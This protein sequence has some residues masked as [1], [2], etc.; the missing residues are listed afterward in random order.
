MHVIIILDYQLILSSKHFLIGI[1]NVCF[2]WTVWGISDALYPM[3]ITTE[4]IMSCVRGY[5]LIIAGNFLYLIYRFI[6]CQILNKNCE[7]SQIENYS[8]LIVTVRKPSKKNKSTTYFLLSCCFPIFVWLL[9]VGF[10][11]I[12]R[13]IFSM[14]DYFLKWMYA[15]GVSNIIMC[16]MLQ[17][18]IGLSLIFTL[19][20]NA[21]NL[22]P[23]HEMYQYDEIQYLDVLLNFNIFTHSYELIQQEKLEKLEKKRE[24]VEK[25]EVLLNYKAKVSYG[26]IAKDIPVTKYPLNNY[27][28]IGS[29]S[30][31]NNIELSNESQN[32]SNTIWK[33][34][35]LKGNFRNEELKSTKT[36]HFFHNSSWHCCCGR[37]L[38]YICTL[39]YR[40]I[41]LHLF[42]GVFW[43]STW[44]IYDIITQHCFDKTIKDLPGLFT[45]ALVCHCLNHLVLFNFK[46]HTTTIPY[47]ALCQFF[48]GINTVFMWASIWYIFDNVASVIGEW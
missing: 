20:D 39:H 29:F 17:I 23:T 19:K 14:V 26:S 12:W 13:G 7:Q 44:R 32:V 5:I 48:S 8:N 30:R 6:F 22:C 46:H 42:G 35:F 27:Y 3:N 21:I 47:K 18:V 34:R 4:G 24:Q 31:N 45:I 10:I 40:H 1:A 33:K 2:W 15:V 37:G 16:L 28:Q 36:D 9:T 11:S 25:E 43:R 38:T 41:V